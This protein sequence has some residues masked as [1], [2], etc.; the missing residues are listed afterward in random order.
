MPKGKATTGNR[1][2]VYTR[3]KFRMGNR[4]STKSGLS[5]SDQELGNIA[6]NKDSGKQRIKALQILDQRG[7]SL[8]SL[9]ATTAE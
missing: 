7:V 8:E 2:L 9:K 5:M 6:M 4:K 3:T 1:K